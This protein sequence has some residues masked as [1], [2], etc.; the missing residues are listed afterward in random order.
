MIFR[1]LL[2]L[3]TLAASNVLAQATFSGTV[4]YVT[5]GDSLWVKPDA[6]GPPRKLRIDGIDAPEICQSGGLAARAVLAQHALHQRVEVT[7]RRLDDYGR[8][9]AH[10]ERE[11]HDLGAQMVGAGQ[12]WS[13]RGRHDRGPYAAEE[14]IARQARR[15]LFAADWPERPRDFRKRNG[16]CHAPG[17]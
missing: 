9:L 10:I 7:V 11:G 8:G 17:G 12:A 3:L 15:G 14:A 4:S 5:D 1:L 16:S 6:G 2:I 13:Y